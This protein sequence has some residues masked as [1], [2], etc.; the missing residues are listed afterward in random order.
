MTSLQEK[1]YIFAY[2]KPKVQTGQPCGP[3]IDIEKDL[4]TLMTE[5]QILSKFIKFL[6]KVDFLL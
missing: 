3:V 4:A 1:A 2:V 5:R 6:E